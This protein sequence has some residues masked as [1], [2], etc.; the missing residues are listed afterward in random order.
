VSNGPPA[1]NQDDQRDIDSTANHPAGEAPA[2]AL[3][4]VPRLDGATA[5]RLFENSRLIADAVEPKVKEQLTESVRQAT[6]AAEAARIAFR[7]F[8]PSSHSTTAREGMTYVAPGSA[9]SSVLEKVVKADLETVGHLEKKQ[10]LSVRLG[11]E[12]MEELGLSPELNQT[13][14]LSKVI[15][16][17]RRRMPLSEV[18]AASRVAQT[19]LAEAQAKELLDQATT[20]VSR[21]RH[22]SGQ[23]GPAP[24]AAQSSGPSTVPEAVTHQL[25]YVTPP[26]EKVVFG[27]ADRAT[28]DDLKTSVSALSIR[29]GPADVTA[30][31][32]FY[33][34][35]IAFRTVW[36]ELFDSDLKPLG[37]LLYENLV[38][39]K[40][41]VNDASAPPVMNTSEDLHQLKND[42][43]GLHETV[44]DADPRLKLVLKQFPKC[45]E[46]L[47]AIMPEAA[48]WALSFQSAE[49]E[50]VIERLASRYLTGDGPARQRDLAEFDALE[51]KGN[52]LLKE[53]AAKVPTPRVDKL[54]EDL[55]LRL[56]ERFAFDVFAKD[57]YNFGILTTYRQRWQPLNYQVGELVSTIP[58]APKEARRFSTKRIVRKSR[59][60]KELEDSLRVKKTDTSESSRS[61]AEIVRSAMNKTGFNYTAEGGFNLGVASAK[62]SHSLAIDATQQSAQTK[63]EFREAVLKA[64]E[65]YKHDHRLE[66]D[67]SAAEEYEEASSGEI[68]NPNDE[69]PVTYLFYELQRR[70]QISERIHKLTPVVLVASDVPNPADIDE[71]WLVAHDWILRKV[72]LDDS[73]RPALDYLSSSFVGDEIATEVLRAEWLTQLDVVEK[74]TQQ[75]TSGADALKAAQDVVKRAL[76][77]YAQSKS[78]E[79]GGSLFGRIFAGI[80]TGGLT[81]LGGSGARESEETLEIRKEAAQEALQRVEREQ[82][83]LRSRLEVELTALSRATE[84]YTTRVEEQFNRRTQ[85]LRLRAHVKDNILYYM[86]AIW[87]HEPPDQRYFR[88]YNRDVLDFSFTDVDSDVLVSVKKSILGGGAGIAGLFILLAAYLKVESRTLVEVAD[89]DTLLG[90]KGNYMIF[91]LRQNNALTMYMMQDYVNLDIAPQL[92]DPDELG[93]Y[94]VDEV[95][96]MVKCMYQQDPEFFD[97]EKKKEVTELLVKLLSS[98]YTASDEVVVPTDSLYIE[99]L[100]GTHPILEDFKLVHRAVDVKKAQADVRHAELENG[101]LAARVLSGEY[102]DP[103]VEKKIIV[104]GADRSVNVSSDTRLSRRGSRWTR[105]AKHTAS[106]LRDGLR[107]RMRSSHAASEGSG[108]E[109]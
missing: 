104:Q 59:S 67:T 19:C 83:E 62:G 50:Y 53:Q 51:K 31:H 80:L 96:E 71:E 54:L 47:W 8:D 70:Y 42:V 11:A 66:I 34:L 72:I 43:A 108:F 106:E 35:Q 44:R 100:P 41:Q 82:Q 40:A 84:R 75:V 88:L 3:P 81:E 49:M 10:G 45:T 9:V 36:E 23:D 5:V 97:E 18:F 78:Q 14:K 102:E 107:R 32:D 77:A 86:Q 33:D 89:L 27:V 52:A 60:A 6:E 2:E 13:V 57:S 25:R 1:D 37:M 29:G 21:S 55:D 61:D 17:I 92:W 76:E 98:P 38:H 69:L 46:D 91:P 30:Y 65:E 28:Q 101:R 64:A 95:L 48:K 16:L 15:D 68:S 26:E 24:R 103:D 4:E 56:K 22:T 99:A 94:T 58:L 105:I 20:E 87:D 85:I 109:G 63:K 74:I 79:E 39:V 7:E 93:N 90:Y 12:E 73:Y